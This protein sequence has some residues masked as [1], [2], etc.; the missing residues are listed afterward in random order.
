MQ[1]ISTELFR[2]PRWVFWDGDL[3]PYPWEGELEAMFRE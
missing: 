3:P 1:P 2:V